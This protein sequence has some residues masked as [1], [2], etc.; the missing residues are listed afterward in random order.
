MYE[1]LNNKN[2]KSGIYN[3]ADD[4][5]LSTNELVVIMNKAL[6]KKTKFLHLPKFIVYAIAKLGGM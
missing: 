3:F 2:L 5:S 4:E 1:M 6:G